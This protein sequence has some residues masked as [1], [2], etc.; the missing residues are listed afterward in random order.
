MQTLPDLHPITQMIDQMQALPQ[1]RQIAHIPA[2]MQF[3]TDRPEPGKSE[4][5]ALPDLL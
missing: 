3:L 1:H 5:Q 4:M 2:Q